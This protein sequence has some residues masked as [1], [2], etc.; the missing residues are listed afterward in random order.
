M[1]ERKGNI[2]QK[3]DHNNDDS[4]DED[5]ARSAARIASRLRDAPVYVIFL[6]L[7]FSQLP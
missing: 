3:N 6:G 2:D 1:E 7:I 5:D 4:D